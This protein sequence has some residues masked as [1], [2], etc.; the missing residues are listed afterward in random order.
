MA[1]SDLVHEPEASMPEGSATTRRG[2]FADQARAWLLAA[3]FLAPALL[4]YIL[5]MLVPMLGTLAL[6]FTEWTGFN[7][8]DVKFVGLN[9]FAMMRDDPIFWLSLRHNLI[10]LFGA[11][12][13][14][15]LV[16]LLLALALDQRV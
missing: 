8:A 15:T 6:G 10:F 11:V 12:S 16:A 13:L 5:F 4:F 3:P 9:N 1:S 2:G 14:K 7:F